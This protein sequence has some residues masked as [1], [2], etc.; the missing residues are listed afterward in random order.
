MQDFTPH[1]LIIATGGTIAG[2]STACDTTPHKKH[3]QPK[4]HKK[5]SQN[6][7]RAGVL[8]IDKI[9]D[10]LHLLDS[11]Y[12]ALKARI[13]T[14]QLANIDSADMNDKI[15]LKLIKEIKKAIPTNATKTNTQSN[16]ID[17]IVITHGTDTLEESAYFLHLC[18]SAFGTKSTTKSTP[19]FGV[20][21]SPIP[22]ILTGAMRPFDALDF[23][24]AQ[25]LYD[26][27]SLA[28]ETPPKAVMVVMNEKIF[29]PRDLSKL[30]TTHIDAFGMSN[31]KT[32]GTIKKGKATFTD[33]RLFSKP[34]AKSL[35]P[36]KWL[37]IA[38]LLRKKRLPK[39][40]ILYS[41][42][43]DASAVAAKAFVKNGAQGLVIAGSGAGSIHKAHKK[44][45]KTLIKKGIAIVVSSRINRGNVAL[46]DSDKNAGFIDSNGLNPQK[47]RVLLALALIYTNDTGKIQKCFDRF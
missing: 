3:E 45:L 31:D 38:D 16:Q 30:H 40:D 11:T 44:T 2:Q 47:A 41:Y 20:Q 12:P 27:I 18:M 35:P 9:L 39:V 21:K 15:W 7:Y 1:I 5:H 23:D 28:C 8:H 25:N 19:Q 29:C 26:A 46:K 14:K 10:S 6:Q 33:F 22:I 32:L 34:N 37:K 13:S 43:N 42:S 24:G 17:G 36:L 4:K